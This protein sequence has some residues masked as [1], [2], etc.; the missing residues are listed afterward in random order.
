M[1]PVHYAAISRD[2]N[3]ELLGALLGTPLTLDIGT[4]IGQ[5]IYFRD[6]AV[7]YCCEITDK[8]E[9]QYCLVACGWVDK[10]KCFLTPT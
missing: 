1:R 8:S 2:S 7:D 10:E 5:S 6:V 4:E 3:T 9:T